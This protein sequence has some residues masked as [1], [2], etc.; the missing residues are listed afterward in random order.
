MR[1][2]PSPPALD[3]IDLAQILFYV[4]GAA[5]GYVG[6]LWFKGKIREHLERLLL[7][8]R[9]EQATPTAQGQHFFGGSP[10]GSFSPKMHS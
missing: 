7:D 10:E 6:Y 5:V 1:L 9:P 3:L 8:C 4:V 2:A